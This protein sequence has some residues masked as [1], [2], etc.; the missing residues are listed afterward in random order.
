[1]ITTDSRLRETRAVAGTALRKVVMRT[2]GRGHGEIFRLISPGDLGEHLKPFVFLDSFGGVMSEFAERGGM[3]PH[4]GIGTVTVFTRGDV[5]FDDPDAGSGY[6]DYG[7]VEWMR[8]GGGVWHGKELSSGRSQRIHG[9]QL[10]LSLPP[11]LELAEVD[12][13]YVEAKDMHRAGPAHVIVGR[14]DGVQSPVR[15]PAGVNYLLVTLAPDE[16]WTYRPPL[17]HTVGWLAMSAGSL[18]GPSAAANGELLIFDSTDGAIELAGG[19]E[20]ATFVLGSAIPH[21]HDLHLGYYSVHTTTE[22]LRTGE[23][24]IETLRLALEREGDRTR[25]SGSTPVFRG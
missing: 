10:W 17:G 6:L 12:S 2:R 4:S 14:Y 22:A 11:E 20:G 25:A 13:Q 24:N 8:A 15:A 7:G 3:H 21:P 23:R 5:H 16:S 19:V 1:M 18:V 9:F